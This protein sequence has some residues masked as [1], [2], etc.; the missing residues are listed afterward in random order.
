M[1]ARSVLLPTA[2]LA[3]APLLAAPLLAQGIEYAPGTTSY[4]VSTATKG[5]QSSPMGSQDFEIGVEQRLTVNVARQS[6]DTLLATFTIDSLTLRSAGPTPDVSRYQGTKLTALLSPTGRVYSSK[7]PEGADPL[8]A[9][10]SESIV[11]FLPSYRRDLRTGLAWSDTASG[12]VT[13][14]GMEVDRTTITDYTVVGDTDVAGQKA[15]KVRRHIA[16]KAA[17][18][19]AAGGTAVTLASSTS[20]DGN[21]VLS[22]GGAFLGSDSNDDIDL[23]LTMAAQGAEISV[24]QKATQKVRAI[25]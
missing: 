18:S 22:S 9:Q 6:K 2:M 4:H 8:L 7:G 21:F 1:R 5:T 25:R 13:Q 3:V 14:Q 19:G 11:R 24:K 10:L 15:F 23:K 16:M 12:K 17:G 20:S